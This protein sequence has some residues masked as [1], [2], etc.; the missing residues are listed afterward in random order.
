MLTRNGKILFGVTLLGKGPTTKAPASGLTFLDTT[1]TECYFNSTSKSLD[2]AY[3]N[4]SVDSVF[5]ITTSPTSS[6]S[7]NGL[8][9]WIGSND[10]GTIA[11]ESDIDLDNPFTSQQ[12]VC[13]FNKLLYA[14][15][16]G[17]II[18]SNFTNIGNDNLSI[19]EIGLYGKSKD[20]LSSSTTNKIIFL[21]RN[22]IDEYT[23][24][25]YESISLDFSLNFN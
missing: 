14:S 2:N 13:G 22:I 17:V 10:N 12:I 8:I 18:Q 11:S 23:L 9:V 1:N 4:K 3:L 15:N 5:D 25:P 6:T 16:G 20:L 7:T 19:K 24:K 21:G